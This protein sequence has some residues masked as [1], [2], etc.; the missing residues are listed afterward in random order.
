M[1]FPGYEAPHAA[2]YGLCAGEEYQLGVNDAARWVT[3]DEH[4]RRVRGVRNGEVHTI[5]DR[6]GREKRIEAETWYGIRGQCPFLKELSYLRHDTFARVPPYHCLLLGLVK[7]FWTAVFQWA[8]KNK[9]PTRTVEALAISKKEKDALDTILKGITLT[10]DFN[11]SFKTGLSGFGRWVCEDIKRFTEV[12][13]VFLQSKRVTGVELP[14]MVKEMWGHLRAVVLHYLNQDASAY[15]QTTREDA[16]THLIQYAKLTERHAPSLLTYN[17]HLAVCRLP[18]QEDT[19]G[20]V[21]S[22][23][24]LW[25]ERALRPFKS[26]TRNKAPIECEK[27]LCNALLAKAS[28]YRFMAVTGGEAGPLWTEFTEEPSSTRCDEV[29]GDA[30]GEVD[31]DVE[32]YDDEDVD[33]IGG[34]GNGNVAGCAV[35]AVDDVSGVCGMLGRGRSPTNDEMAIIMSAIDRLVEDGMVDDAAVPSRHRGTRTVEG[36]P[37]IH[38]RAFI[39]HKW[40]VHSTAYGR[41]RTRDT[42]M[43]QVSYDGVEWVCLAKFFVRVHLINGEVLR[44]GI[45]DFFPRPTNLGDRRLG[46]LLST[47]DR[48]ANPDY[49]VMLDTIQ[50][51]LAYLRCRD[52]FGDDQLHFVKYGFA[53]NM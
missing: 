46:T 37:W 4:T 20:L 43:L 19:L 1:V 29:E 42:R 36:T 47:R 53:S 5:V 13:S 21:G 44:L 34:V 18:A 40:T 22:M 38:T 7:D 9:M 49:P 2:R 35:C 15:N 11:R 16:R 33:N 23:G 30:E 27:V 31:G 45:A 24:E 39:H 52:R 25:G 32:A 8:P 3:A 50:R 41:S 17:L 28:L 26:I 48:I 12:F 10:A 14:A 51:P 6:R